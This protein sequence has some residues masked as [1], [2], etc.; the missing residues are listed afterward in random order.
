MMHFVQPTWLGH[1]TCSH[2]NAQPSLSITITTTTIPTVSSPPSTSNPFCHHHN[3]S[4]HEK[5][6]PECRARQQRN[7]NRSKTRKGGEGKGSS[8]AYKVRR[9]FNSFIVFY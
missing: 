7:Q 3:T 5:T 9:F 8:G 4:R 6:L 2:I 1:V